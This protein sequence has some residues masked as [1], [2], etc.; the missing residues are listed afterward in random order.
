MNDHKAP[1][2]GLIAGV[3]AALAVFVSS[4]HPNWMHAV[5]F[6][7]ISLII[8]TVVAASHNKEINTA[9]ETK[10]DESRQEKTRAERELQKVRANN[11]DLKRR[12]CEISALMLSLQSIARQIGQ[13]LEYKKILSFVMDITHRS[14]GAKK[15]SL[16]LVDPETRELRLEET[17]GWADVE[18]A[19]AHAEWGKGV[20]GVVLEKKI[21]LDAE[22]SKRDP[23]LLGYYRDA[24]NPSMIC[25]P[26]IVGGEVVGVLNVEEFADSKKTSVQDDVRLATFLA[27]LAAMSIKNSRLFEQAQDKA[28]TD[29]LTRL[30]THRY[31]QDQLDQ[32]IRRSERYGDCLSLILTDIDHFKK[33]NDTY[34]H[35]TGD[36]VLRETAS[37]FKTVGLDKSATLARY[38]GEEFIVVLPH[39]D[40]NAAH[41]AAERLRKAVES[42][43]CQTEAGQL[44]VTISL[45][46]SS[47]PE[48]AQKKALLI[49]M[50]DHALYRAKKGGRNRVQVAAPEDSQAAEK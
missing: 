9:T 38:G 32:E 3:I 27:S 28:N 4:D 1:I 44:K 36:L 30:Y 20:I 7:S 10:V 15:C 17:F 45:G 25:A 19:Q 24:K 13:S 49:E 21:T 8:V 33:F 39:A 5:A 22:T 11:E 26:L 41:E 50:A 40:K 48:D 47:F 34:G 29:G 16:W 43:T 6:G 14:V 42:R 37:C 2:L 18:K 35:Q 12:N 23:G 46:V 31:F